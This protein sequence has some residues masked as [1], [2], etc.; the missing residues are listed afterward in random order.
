MRYEIDEA[1]G[2]GSKVLR[3]LARGGLIFADALR[4]KAAPEFKKIFAE[5]VDPHFTLRRIMLVR[6]WRW[7]KD[8]ICGTYLCL[9][10]IISPLCML[11]APC[12]LHSIGPTATWSK[13]SRYH[14]KES[15]LFILSPGSICIS[16]IVSR[17]VSD[18]TILS[19]DL[20]DTPQHIALHI[21]QPDQSTL[22]HDHHQLFIHFSNPASSPRQLQRPI[23]NGITNTCYYIASS[24]IADNISDY[25]ASG[26]RR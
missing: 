10:Y 8:G 20:N 4:R 26:M 12:R 17:L 24:I 13:I 18:L 16:A 14:L 22:E 5:V 11:P 25:H 2:L 3:A 7:T 6:G 19:I 1:T 23:S 15:S 21:L 9:F